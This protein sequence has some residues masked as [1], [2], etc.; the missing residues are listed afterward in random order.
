MDTQK[1]SLMKGENK[2][3]IVVVCLR[4]SWIL[5]EWNIFRKTK[6]GKFYVIEGLAGTAVR[7]N[8]CIIKTI[9]KPAKYLNP[10]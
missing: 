6:C 5:V 1:Q 4:E 7:Q 10:F 3:V 9:E 8:V 2:S